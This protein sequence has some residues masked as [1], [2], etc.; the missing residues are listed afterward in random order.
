M[1]QLD[2]APLVK[3]YR[4]AGSAAYHPQMLASLL[5]YGCGRGTYSSRMNERASYEA[6]AFRYIAANK[7]P[8]HDMLCAFRCRF[9]PQLE[10]LF[11]QVLRIARKMKLLKL[12]SIALDGT[13][14][15]AN[16][17]RHS[18]LSYKRSG[19]IEEQFKAEITQLLKRAESRWI[20]PRS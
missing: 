4:G 17:S 11:V 18:A 13:K 6:I 9:L 3:A 19:E 10:A 1:E 7:H 12:G 15:H 5:I 16:A 8:D 20:S 2:F 14:V